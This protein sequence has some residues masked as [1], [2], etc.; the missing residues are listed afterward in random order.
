MFQRGSGILVPANRDVWYGTMGVIML[1]RA[2][3]DQEPGSGGVSLFHSGSLPFSTVS[4]KHPHFNKEG[5]KV[6]EGIPC[7]RRMCLHLWGCVVIPEQG[8]RVPGQWW[9]QYQHSPGWWLLSPWK[10]TLYKDAVDLPCFL[11]LLTGE[12]KTVF[13]FSPIQPNT[14]RLIFLQ[15][16]EKF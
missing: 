4:V 5:A 9:R 10:E 15:C 14:Q 2:G 6:L 3:R 1:Y 8:Q 7:T 16:S 11:F 12:S 13:L